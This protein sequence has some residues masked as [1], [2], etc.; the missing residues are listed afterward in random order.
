MLVER[1][2]A[3]SREAPER[4]AVRSQGV[5]PMTRAE[6]AAAARH[7]AVAIRGCWDAGTHDGPVAVVVDGTPPSLA[8]LV[9]A[10]ECGLDVVAVE[11]GAPA[12]TGARDVL[13][14]LDVGVVVAAHAPGTWPG[15]TVLDPA[16]L[17][18]AAGAATPSGGVTDPAGEADLLQLTSGSSG[19]PRLARQTH[20]GAVAAALS[21]V[22]RFQLAADD[23]VVLPVS[24][25]HSYGMAGMLSA[26]IVGGS[27]TSVPTFTPA[28]A[29]TALRDATVLFGTP[30]MYRYLTVGLLGRGEAGALRAAVSAGAPLD[31]EVAQ[32]FRDRTGVV[33]RQIYGSTEAGLIACT[34]VWR[35]GV[36]PDAVGPPAPGVDVRVARDGELLVRT[37]SL[38]RGYLGDEAPRRE[39]GF[40]PTGDLGSLGEDGLLRITGRKSHFAKIGGRRVGLALVEEAMRACPGVVDAAARSR[41]APDGDER[42]VGYVVLDGVAPGD[43]L[44]A[45][46]GGGLAPYEVPSELRE[47]PELPRNHLGKVIAE[48]LDVAAEVAR[49]PGG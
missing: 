45:L 1:L 41:A 24:A 4:I 30:L 28:G 32:T 27:V 31:A 42:L 5:R 8:S 29:V 16:G 39:D 26:L 22:D 12:L 36:P 14:D 19:R 37:P 40:Q 23:V 9:G 33:I 44:T 48:A 35:A 3:L 34:P 17:R 20:A 2:D 18:G 15:A 6:F 47:L 43:V 21:Y 11:A 49:A 46:R 10:L 13:A 7:A 38:M 25:A